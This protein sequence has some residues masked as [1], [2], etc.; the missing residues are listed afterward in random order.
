MPFSILRQL[1]ISQEK[2]YRRVEDESKFILEGGILA[3][4]F[5]PMLIKNS[6]HFSAII[7]LSVTDVL[8]ILKLL[9]KFWLKTL[10]FP[11]IYFIVFQVVLM[12]FFI[13]LVCFD[14][15]VF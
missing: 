12:L 3:A 11:I 9:G 14:N 2:L 5:D 1:Q 4:K 10:Y 8:F 13:F 7:F 15:N 6:L